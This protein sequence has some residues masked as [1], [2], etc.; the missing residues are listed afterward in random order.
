MK[1]RN[2]WKNLTLL[3]ISVVLVSCSSEKKDKSKKLS[4]QE[5]IHVAQVYKPAQLYKELVS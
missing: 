1:N 3:A 4:D 5:N 2:Y